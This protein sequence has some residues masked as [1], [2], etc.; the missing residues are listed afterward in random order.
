MQTDAATP[1]FHIIEGM[2]A[3]DV[4]DAYDLNGIRE[5][6]IELLSGFDMPGFLG[7]IRCREDLERG[8]C[9][10]DADVDVFRETLDDAE[11]LG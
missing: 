2:I 6:V 9:R 3:N 11:A 10:V 5:P 7:F 8:A 4:D 1:V